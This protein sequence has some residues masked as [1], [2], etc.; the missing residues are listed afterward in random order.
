[1]ESNGKTLQSVPTLAVGIVHAP[2]VTIEF[3]C[4]YT[5][6]GVTLHGTHEFHII[7]GRVTTNDVSV[8]GLKLMPTQGN[9][10]FTIRDVEIGIGFHWDKREDQVFGGGLSF[11]IE[12]GMLWA[13]NHVDVESYLR[14]VIASEMSAT[15]DLELLKAHAVTSRSWLMA[16]VWGKGKFC[17]K[18]G[19]CNEDETVVWRDREDHRLF[20]VC[21]DDH[22]QRYQ[23]L[24]RVTNHNVDKALADTRGLVLMY[25]GEVCDARFSKCC[26]GRTEVFSTCWGDKPHHYLQSFHDAMMPPLQFRMG[27]DGFAGI[28]TEADAEAWIMGQPEAFCNTTDAGVLRQVLND[29]DQSTTDFFRWQVSASGKEF[30][31]LI[32]NKGGFDLGDVCDLQPLHRGPSGRIDRLKIVGS[33]GQRI[34]GK[35]LEI[36]RL[37]SKTHLYSSAFVVKKELDEKDDCYRFTLFGAG[38]GHGVGLCQIGAAVMARKGFNFRSILYHYFRRAEIEQLW[39]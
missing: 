36:R 30:G 33:K 22:C 16:Q 13:V 17:G 39:R 11:V 38:W 21:A 8:D 18:Q 29:Y 19:E 26:G 27:E 23:G 31:E 7:D 9:G 25:D 6:Q 35:E 15:S 32:R 14:S 12:D 5:D 4:P 3:G 34:V 1:M 2:S 28:T 10:T 24:S 37:L 20:D